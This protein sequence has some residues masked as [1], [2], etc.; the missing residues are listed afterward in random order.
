MSNPRKDRSLAALAA[1]SGELAAA[2]AKVDQL[3]ER[4][5]LQSVKAQRDGAS[6][7]EM[8]AATELSR[9]GVTKMLKRGKSQL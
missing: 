8:G 1:V 3:I 7:E 2:H 6:Y 4:R 9:M 5:D